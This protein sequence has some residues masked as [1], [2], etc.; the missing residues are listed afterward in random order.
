MSATSGRYLS[1]ILYKSMKKMEK[2]SLI[3][4]RISLHKIE[5]YIEDNQLEQ[6]GELTFQSSNN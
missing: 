5:K 2:E 1:E 3:D 6:I 4:Q